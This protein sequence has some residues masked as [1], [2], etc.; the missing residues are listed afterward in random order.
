MCLPV[1]GLFVVTT[2]GSFRALNSLSMAVYVPPSLIIWPHLFG[3]PR[4]NLYSR[5]FSR[6][7]TVLNRTLPNFDGDLM[8]RV[9]NLLVSPRR[10]PSFP[11]IFLASTGLDRKGASFY[12][13]NLQRFHAAIAKL[14]DCWDAVRPYTNKSELMPLLNCLPRARIR[15][16]VTS[17]FQFF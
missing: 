13:A 14:R 17:Q 15:D 9:R 7:K 4:R 12:Q 6:R 2:W 1:L 10:T 3:R 8:V 5:P 11:G 16:K